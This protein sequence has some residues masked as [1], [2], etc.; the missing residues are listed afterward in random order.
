V[1]AIKGSRTKLHELVVLSAVL[2]GLPVFGVLGIVLGPVV[3][4]ITHA[5]FDTLRHAGQATTES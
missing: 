2:G 4:V 3:L 5:L 1:N